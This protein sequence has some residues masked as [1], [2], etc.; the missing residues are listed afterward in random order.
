MTETEPPRQRRE[1]EEEQGVG[2]DRFVLV[3]L[4]ESTLWPI[5][6]VIVGHVVVFVA[7][8]LLL[9]VREHRTSAF[10]VIAG[11]CLGTIRMVRFDKRRSGGL[12]QLS[13]LAAVTWVLI[14]GTAA[15][16]HRTGIF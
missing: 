14:L 7:P 12:S 15:L 5:L 10:I 2:V 1:D 8:V 13:A 11:F 9:A 4:R 3:F 16:A 6:I